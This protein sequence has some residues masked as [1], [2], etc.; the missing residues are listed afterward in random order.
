MA[1]LGRGTREGAAPVVTSRVPPRADAPL[2]AAAGVCVLLVGALVL[3][4]GSPEA[5][6]LVS[7]G[8]CA[9]LQVAM[10]AFAAAAGR[11]LHRSS[12]A[13]RF[14]LGYAA[15]GFVYAI[16]SLVQVVS[17]IADPSTGASETD[18]KIIC[19][20]AGTAILLVVI[21]G[22][23][24]GVRSARERVRLWFDLGAVTIGAASFGV[25]WAGTGQFGLDPHDALDVMSGPV[26][27]FAVVFAVAKL[28]LTG[29]PPF[30]WQ[31]GA[32]GASAGLVEGV[33]RG[34]TPVIDAR[35]LFA[36]TV[37]AHVLLMASA[38][39]QYRQLTEDPSAIRDSGRRRPFSALP[40]VAIAVSCGLLALSL[41]A[42][43][44]STRTWLLLAGAVIS[45]GFVVARQVTAL[46][47]NARLLAELDLKVR[48]LNRAEGLLRGA[49]AGQAPDEAFADRLTGLANRALFTVRLE[50][51]W[52]SACGHDG[53]IGVMLINLDKFRPLNDSLGEAAGDLLLRQAGARL[54][55]CVREAD[56]VAR[57]GGDE[58]AVLLGKPTL[59]NLHHV[60]RRVVAA[61][62]DPYL[63]WGEQVRLTASIGIA[64]ERGQRTD[65]E[66]LMRDADEA[67]Y[68][69]KSRGRGDAEI[70]A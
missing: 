7:W 53:R 26:P 58:F 61:L 48:E 63:I 43:G 25:F 50:D 22:F 45:T 37:T 6:A 59:D 12:P 54:V 2:F 32:L 9:V 29:R 47:D 15:A 49:M 31:T 34:I 16:G 56:V 51:A 1:R 11:R 57:L 46:A 67:L 55:G 10:C 42:D 33:A 17:T 38:R 70:Y 36:L 5:Q 21:L 69:A 68:A 30:T 64:V 65:A 40:Y 66:H 4:A 35:G 27:T 62:A 28:L 52:A 19:V 14:W 44:A 18:L 60:A 41:A 20:G 24:L 39:V 23:P 13:R 3:D 8:T